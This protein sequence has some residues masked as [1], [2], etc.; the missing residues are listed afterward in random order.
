MFKKL[1]GTCALS[2]LLCTQHAIALEWY[3]QIPLKIVQTLI[4]APLEKDNQAKI[5]PS[6]DPKQG[7]SV[8]RPSLESPAYSRIKLKKRQAVLSKLLA[9]FRRRFKM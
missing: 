3:A 7:A 5:A 4:Q 8:R 1:Y 2:V 6:M 9:A